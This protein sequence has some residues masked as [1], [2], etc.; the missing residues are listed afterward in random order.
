MSA[1]LRYGWNAYVGVKAPISAKRAST[2]DDLLDL[3]EV[4]SNN[5]PVNA[6]RIPPRDFQPSVPFLTNQR[7]AK[8]GENA[9]RTE[10]SKCTRF[11]AMSNFSSGMDRTNVDAK[12]EVECQ[13][14]DDNGSKGARQFRNSEGLQDE[15]HDE[16][17]A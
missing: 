12:R 14:D 2:P 5:E 4:S 6:R 17:S 3:S 8:C 1:D 9:L 16:N 13:P 7:A 15:E 10:W 11:Y